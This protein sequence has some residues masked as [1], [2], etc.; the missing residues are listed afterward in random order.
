VVYEA[1]MVRA[2]GTPITVQVG[3]DFTVTAVLEGGPGG[4]P[5]PGGTGGT[6]SSGSATPSSA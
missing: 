3:K 6:T 5:A 4:R 1:H 2:D